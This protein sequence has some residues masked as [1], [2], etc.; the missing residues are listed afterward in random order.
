MTKVSIIVPIYNIRDYLPECV[1]SLRNQTLSDIQIIL[2]DDGSTD[3]SGQIIDSFA[4]QDARILALH[5]ENGG[6]S[7]ARNMGFLY[8]AGEYILYV[9][10]DDYVIPET[11]ERLYTAAKEHNADIVHGDLLNDADRLKDSAF[12]KLSFENKKTSVLSYIK[13]V[14]EKEIYDIVPFLY[15][16]RKTYLEQHNFRFAEGYFYEDQLY[17]MQLLSHPEASI[18]KIRFPFYYYRMDRPGSTTNH[19]TLK[20]GMDSA[21]ICKEMYKYIRQHIQ[22][23]NKTCYD[24]ILLISLYQYYRVYLRMKRRDRKRVWEALDLVQ[25]V[26]SLETINYRKLADELNHFLCNRRMAELKWDT[27]QLIRKLLRR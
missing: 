5:K 13:E 12:R 6:Q 14:I 22:D 24:A 17:T 4:A 8:A 16:V 15:L 25:I 27:R 10:G 26:G 18:V 23:E 3:G 1:D 19:M 21:Y 2:V 7:S 9:D 20:K 11:V